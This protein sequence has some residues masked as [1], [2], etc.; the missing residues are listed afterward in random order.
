[1][2][3][4]WRKY[5]G[6]HLAIILLVYPAFVGSRCHDCSGTRNEPFPLIVCRCQPSLNDNFNHLPKTSQEIQVPAFA[7]AGIRGPPAATGT[8]GGSYLSTRCRLF[9]AGT[10]PGRCRE[11]N[12]FHAAHCIIKDM[13]AD[14]ELH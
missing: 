1:M 12:L 5:C 13:N 8:G 4:R 9:A 11:Y 6:P 10:I 14:C 7:L 3:S 2:K